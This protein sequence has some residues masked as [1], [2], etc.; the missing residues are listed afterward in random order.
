MKPEISE[1]SY[2]YAVT[3]DIVHSKGPLKAAPFFPSLR[4]EGTKGGFDVKLNLPGSP[5]FLQ[6][7]L[8]DCMIGSTASEAQQGLFTTPFF[9]MHIRPQKKSRQ[10]KLLLDLEA[11]GNA[12]YYVA[13][14]FHEEKEFNLAYTSRSILSKSVMISPAA[15]GQLPDD[16]N[17]HISFK[18]VQQRFGYL[19]SQSARKVGILS[20]E[21]LI[22]RMDQEWI[23]TEYSVQE[24]LPELQTLLLDIISR[25]VEEGIRSD[26][27]P[28]F[29]TGVQYRSVYEV[30]EVFRKELIQ[31]FMA[32]ED[33][34]SRV[35][36][37]SQAFFN[38]T[39]FIVQHNT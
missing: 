34:I 20:W 21:D 24:L 28:E 15:I 32:D 33:P 5:L 23:R 4:S 7:K 13:P 1:F 27:V 22:G 37:L 8:S 31:E 30:Q 10:H 9:R 39:L 17:H 12:V 35:A 19:L 2:G 3:E 16:E 36:S 26:S 29:R 14:A 18:N 25:Q 38:C 11:T 6:F